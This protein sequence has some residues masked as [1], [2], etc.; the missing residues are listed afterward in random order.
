[1]PEVQAGVFPVVVQ[2]V[3]GTGLQQGKSGLK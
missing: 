1:M 2:E 3:K